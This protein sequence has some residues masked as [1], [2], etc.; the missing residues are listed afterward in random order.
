MPRLRTQS[1]P[2]VKPSLIFRFMSRTISVDIIPVNYHLRDPNGGVYSSGYYGGGNLYF[3]GDPN[4]FR[5]YTKTVVLPKGSIPGIWGLQE[6]LVID[7]AGNRITHDFTEIV[8]FEVDD[9]PAAPTLTV[10]L[11]QKTEL[12]ANYPNPFNPETWIPYQL[13]KGAEVS[14]TIYAIDGYIVRR[15]ALGHQPLVCMRTVAVQ[16]IGMVETNSVSQWQAVCISIHLPQAISL[17]RGGCLS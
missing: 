6:M 11:P 13:A 5:K 16:R 17:R 2:M 7:K 14:L 3:Q 9:A 4:V 1:P 10:S 8:R 12:L 15:L